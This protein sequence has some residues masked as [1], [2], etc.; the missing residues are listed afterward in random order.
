MK[1]VQS[2]ARTKTSIQND[3][4]SFSNRFICL[5]VSENILGTNIVR[6]CQGSSRSIPEGTSVSENFCNELS[7]RNRLVTFS[8]MKY[9]NIC[10]M[11]LFIS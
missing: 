4:N 3:Y 11:V 8:D 6:C 5:Y 9:R 1:K 2:F 10:Y 7:S